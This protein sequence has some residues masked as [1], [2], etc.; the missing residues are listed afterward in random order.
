MKE[1]GQTLKMVKTGGDESHWFAGPVTLYHKKRHTC[2]SPPHSSVNTANFP[3]QDL[4]WHLNF[5]TCNYTCALEPLSTQ[6]FMPLGYMYK[7]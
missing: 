4:T 2:G 5:P 3:E 7:H 6:V 1:W